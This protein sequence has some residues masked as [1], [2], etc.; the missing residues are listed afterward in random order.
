MYFQFKKEVL[1]ALFFLHPKPLLPHVPVLRSGEVHQSIVYRSD[2]SRG[3][4]HLFTPL[5][6]VS[7]NH[8]DRLYFYRVEGK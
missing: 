3:L 2:I 7:S 1:N 6:C 8:R 5:H 4:V